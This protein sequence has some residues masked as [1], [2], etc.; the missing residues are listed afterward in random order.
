MLAN[1]FAS[2]Q[3]H[4]R[5]TGLMGQLGYYTCDTSTPIR[6]GTWEAVYWSAQCAI[7]GAEA[8]LVDTMAY[9]LCRPPGHHA[10]SDAAAGFCYLNNTAVAA[11]H[12]RALTSQRVAV[13]DVD[14]HHGNGTQAIFYSDAD[15]LT[16]SIHCDPSDYYPFFSGYDDEIGTGLG[17][18]FNLNLPLPPGSGDDDFAL[19][20]EVAL[21]RISAHAPAA[22]VIAL[23]LDASE[24]DP[25]GAFKLTESGFSRMG[26]AISSLKLPTLFVQEGG[27]LCDAL[28]RNLIAV[29]NAA[30]A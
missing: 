5:P 25:I 4:R 14:V 21:A 23:G 13:L 30:M 12:L 26:R 19:A 16:V 24:H 9:A 17:E 2:P 8:A 6:A 1:H 7:S 3:M 18:A 11:A 20:L 29:L 10:F 15:V 27:Y 22:L 28:P